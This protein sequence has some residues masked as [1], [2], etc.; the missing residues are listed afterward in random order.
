MPFDPFKQS[1]I[2]QGYAKV[3]ASEKNYATTTVYDVNDLKRLAGIGTGV[4]NKSIAPV[5]NKAQLM[6][7]HNIQPGTEAWFKLWF[8]K[9][10][11]TG[12]KPIE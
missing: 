10:E 9:P 8:A 11:L 6:K 3:K 7:Q 2:N 12:E 5:T 4:Y 1:K